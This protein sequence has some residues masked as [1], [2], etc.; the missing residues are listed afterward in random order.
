MEYYDDIKFTAIGRQMSTFYHADHRWENYGIAFTRQGRMK[1][2]KN[3]QAERVLDAPFVYW[4]SPDNSYSHGCFP[5]ESRDHSWCF[6]IGERI[7]RIT[8][9][10]LDRLMPEGCFQIANP[11][12]MSRLYDYMIH[13]YELKDTQSHFKITI[14]LEQVV[15]LIV[16]S[17]MDRQKAH[18]PELHRKIRSIASAVKKNPFKKWDF[19]ELSHNKIFVS[20]SYFR[21]LFTGI[22][23]T[24]PTEYLLLCRMN[25]ATKMLSEGEFQIQEIAGRCGY[26]N[27][28]AFTRSFKK[29]VGLSPSAYVLH[30]QK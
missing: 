3:K 16:E 26:D 23:N 4:Y 7:R 15:G 11:I 20:Y 12:E 2:K 13:L 8:S 29:K 9:A 30:L 5:G 21:Q 1:F 19:H 14:A 18:E 10:V 22:M 24:P 25:A 28:S 17:Y 6:C 27:A